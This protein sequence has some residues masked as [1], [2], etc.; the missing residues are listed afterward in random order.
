MIYNI[1]FVIM[2]EHSVVKE[3]ILLYVNLP[4][5]AKRKQTEENSAWHNE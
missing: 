5:I 1:K 4:I 2:T 3:Q